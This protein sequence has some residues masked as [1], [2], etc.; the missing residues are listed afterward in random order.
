MIILQ[1]NSELKVLQ[2]KLILKNSIDELKKGFLN[3]AIA[4]CII[5]KGLIIHI[6]WLARNELAKKYVDI[7]QKNI[8]WTNTA[9]W[10]NAFT[11][12]EYRKNGL[13]SFTHKYIQTYL[14]KKDIKYNRFSI[15]KINISSINAMNKFNPNILALGINIKIYIFNFRFTITKAKKND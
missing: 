1:N 6:T 11:M 13:Y 10:G 8:N 15:K 12:P 9:V 14:F 3:K 4:F 7:W 5:N 2:E